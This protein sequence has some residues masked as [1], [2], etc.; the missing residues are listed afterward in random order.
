[1][2]DLYIIYEKIMISSNYS[3]EPYGDW[4]EEY[5]FKLLNFSTEKPKSRDYSK[6]VVDF[7]SNDIVYAIYGIYSIG[8]SFGFSE[9]N[10]EILEVF[11]NIEKAKEFQMVAEAQN[12]LRGDFWNMTPKEKASKK[13]YLEQILKKHKGS[14]E[15]DIYSGFA[16]DGK[17]YRVPWGGYFENLDRIDIQP[18]LRK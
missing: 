9:G 12:E 3:N 7:E 14:Y 1:M 5:Q 10:G 11:D 8:D 15:E 2:Y 16:F 18:L 17:P 13:Y 4:N 6:F